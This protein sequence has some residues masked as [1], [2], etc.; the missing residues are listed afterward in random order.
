MDD[1]ARQLGEG[2]S[3]VANTAPN[4]RIAVVIPCYKVRDTILDVVRR[5]PSSVELIICVDDKCP[6]GSGDLLKE[7][8]SD[9]R[10]VILRNPYNRGV[11]GAVI[12]GYRAA[13]ARSMDIVVKIDGDGQMD[14]ALLSD[15]VEPL[16]QGIA[17]YTKGNRFFWPESTQ[18]MPVIR[19]VGNA[20]LSFLTKASSGYWRIMDPTNGYTA[21]HSAALRALPLAKIAERYFFESDMLFRLY[22]VRAVV[23]DVPMN[24]RYGNE[25]SSLS[26]TRVLVPFLFLNIQNIFKRF[27]YNYI[28]RDFNI[29]SV[30][31]LLGF[32][33]IAFGAI[34]GLREWLQSYALGTTASAGTVMVAALPI[35]VGLQLVLT[36]MSFDLTNAPQVPLQRLSRQARRRDAN[37]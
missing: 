6:D 21:I 17:D 29:A 2:D 16:V 19:L 30:M 23:L 31:V 7:E 24:A 33:L 14:P 4:P 26:I 27:Y 36:A 13:L 10:L 12:A 18:G 28:L 3:A 11:G 35:I 15:L 20:G 8:C 5:V 25:K 37:P 22:T 32:P 9:P 34:F 1:V